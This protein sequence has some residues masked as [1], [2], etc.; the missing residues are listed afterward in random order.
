MKLGHAEEVKIWRT[1]GTGALAGAV[2]GASTLPFT[3]P[4]GAHL[5]FVAVG[6]GAGALVA[7]GVLLAQWIRGDHPSE[8]AGPKDRETYQAQWN[9]RLARRLDRVQATV[10]L[11]F[12]YH[13]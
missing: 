10:Y 2:L 1:L 3:N 13:F 4:P 11:P 7:A 9:P 8:Y 12:S 6:A 5:D